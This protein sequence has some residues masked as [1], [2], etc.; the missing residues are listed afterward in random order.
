M[1]FKKFK[2][3]ENLNAR[4][5][6]NFNILFETMKEFILNKLDVS[7]ND[8]VQSIVEMYH[9]AADCMKVKNGMPNFAKQ[10]PWWDSEC[11]RLKKDKFKAL[12]YFRNES[13]YQNL[14]NY[15]K[16]RN[17]FKDVCRRKK[18]DYQKRNRDE[19]VASRSNMNLFWRTVKKFRFKKANIFSSIKPQQWISHFKN[20]LC[21]PNLDYLTESIDDYRKD[22]AF[23][24]IFN[25][26]FT[27]S[28][29]QNSI[30]CLK[31]G[32]SGGPDGLVAEMIINTTNGISTIL[33]P[34]FNKILTLGE[35]PE[36][37][38]LSILCPILKSG[39]MSDPNNFR[40]VSLIDILNK[41]LTG[42][43]Y[44][45]I[46]N[47]AEDNSK[48]SES[49][50]GFRKGYSTIDNIFTLMSLGQKY[51]SKKGG[52][53]Y[54]LFVDFSKAFDRI[55]H[56]ILINSLI[57][58]GFHGRMLKLLIAMYSNLCSCVKIDNQK[59]TSHFK[60]NIGTRQG[61]KLSTILF[62]LF[63]N[64]LIG[65][66][67]NSGIKGI[68]ISSNDPDVLTILYADDMANVG[69]TVRALQAQ[70]DIIARFCARTNMKINLQKTKVIVFRN[71]GI[72]R[73]YEKWYFNGAAIETVSAYKYMGLFITPKL[74]WS[75][76]KHNLAVQARKSIISMLKLQ[77][78]VGY[79]GYPELF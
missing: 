61:C 40:G 54:C 8:C 62:I 3:R 75:Y 39:S 74:I 68:Q 13:N 70:I 45:R 72:L 52:R 6:N 23:N 69:D 50:A 14:N 66:L 65:E 73:Y 11:E 44:N 42:M 48:L 64:D 25:Q 67:N 78:S 16:L 51:L 55:D 10:E 2:W 32:K 53:F 37:W 41:I 24:D 47:W 1:T 49:Q 79:F 18:L 9:K 71:G 4:F 29:L 59:C 36:N 20:L 60:C 63:I 21:I 35:Y 5:I 19:L 43:M 46:Y 27:M 38:S 33:L 30:K 12:R 57:K 76:A 15:K 7:I 22:G 77:S 31:L 26:E 58:K 34:L 17:R 28:E 56:K